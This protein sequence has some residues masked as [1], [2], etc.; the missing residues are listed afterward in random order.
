MP[1]KERTA[2]M[3]DERSQEEQ[4]FL[5]WHEKVDECKRLQERIAKIEAELQ[6]L[7]ATDWGRLVRNAIDS[8]ARR[9]NETYHLTHDQQNAAGAAIR[10]TVLAVI[11]KPSE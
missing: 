10:R 5:A 1:M 4:I 6:S 7:R 3:A 8:T 9:L 2:L 11:W